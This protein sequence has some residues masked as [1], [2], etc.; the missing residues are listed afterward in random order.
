MKA[1]KRFDK[2][3][4]ADILQVRKTQP[5]RPTAT[6]REILNEVKRD[7]DKALYTFSK[8]FDPVPISELG[9][10]DSALFARAELADKTLRGAIRQAAANIRKF[11]ANQREEL[12]VVETMP[13]VNCWR[14]SNPIESV[15]LYVPGGSAPLV[16]T[17]LMLGV[18]ALLAGCNRITV[19]TP[20]DATGQLDPGIAAVAVELGLRDIFLVGGAQAIGALAYGTGSILAVDK[21]FG[22]GNQ[23]VTEAKRLVAAEGVAIDLLAGPSEVCVIADDG[24]N[25]AFVAADL[26][27]QAE[28]GEESEVLFLTPSE[29][30]FLTVAKELERQLADLPRASIAKAA[31]DRS[32]TFIVPSLEEAVRMSNEYAPEHLILAVRNPRNL[33]DLV[34]NAGS[35]FLGDLSP[36]AVGDYASGTNHTL[37]TGGAA[38]FTGGVSLE[39]FLK[40]VTFQ[41]VT[42][43]GLK[44]I[45]PVVERLAA[46]EGLE[47]HGQAVRIRYGG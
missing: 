27:S 33:S 34:T 43:E 38:R 40:K 29:T 32:Y 5:F 47:G 30:L 19:I 14:R 37:P 39:S 16:S 23:Y 18:P 20:P 44:T 17:L 12:K 15:G 22:P 31:L 41:E 9:V 24:A 45:G 4:W 28:H 35:V 2:N 10:A 46:A 36:E 8:K 3:A 7:G 42:L 25:A 11:H 6:V 13:G 26:L 21:I 1:F